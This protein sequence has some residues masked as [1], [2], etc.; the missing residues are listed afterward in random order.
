MGFVSETDP[1]LNVERVDVPFGDGTVTTYLAWPKEA[2]NAPAIILLHENTGTRPHF[3]D[4]ARRLAKEGFLAAA[5]DALSLVG[6]TPTS[7]DDATA[8]IKELDRPDTVNL[9]GAVAAHLRDHVASNGKV[10]AWGFCWGGGMANQMAVAGA[11]IDAAIVF[12]GGSPD[13]ADVPK[14]KVP[15]MLNYAENDERINAGVPG[16]EA[17]LKAAGTDY[18]LHMYKD[19]GHAFFNDDRE[20]RYHA[21]ASQDAWGRVLAFLKKTI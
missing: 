9:F 6:G 10:C 3:E 4:V 14:I 13:D 17:A 20:D 12:Y 16:Y 5:P 21:G 18:E 19:A 15:M 1:D 7:W 2:T 11:N 8:L